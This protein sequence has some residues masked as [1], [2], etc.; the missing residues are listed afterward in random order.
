LPL[1]PSHSPRRP[2]L[3]ASGP[4]APAEAEPALAYTVQASDKLIVLARDLLVN[5]KAWGEVAKFNQLKNPDLI[6]PGQRIQI[7]LRL[8]KYNPASARV[9]SVAGDAR[10][11]G[12]P[13]T[14]GMPLTE[15][16]RLQTGSNSSVVVEL[17]DGSKITML[18]NTLAD[19]VNNR[20]YLM[21]DAGASA[22]TTWFSGLIRLT[23]GALEAAALAGHQRA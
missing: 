7:P 2:S 8:L 16:S 13:A 3:A 1:P 4:K 18:P 21:R 23:Q 11:G 22:S 19:V 15:G 17:G 9:I 14:V 10:L 6:K 12:A 20:S 5:P